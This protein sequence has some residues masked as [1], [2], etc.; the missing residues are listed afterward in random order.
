M[1][2]AVQQEYPFGQISYL[3]AFDDG[4]VVPNASAGQGSQRSQ[5]SLLSMS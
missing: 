4:I 3:A 5:D 1:P 2:E